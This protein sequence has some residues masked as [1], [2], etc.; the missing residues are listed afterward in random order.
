[1]DNDH[2]ICDMNLIHIAPQGGSPSD[3]LKEQTVYKLAEFITKMGCISLQTWSVV[4][5]AF[6]HD[7]HLHIYSFTMSDFKIRKEST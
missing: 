4:I 3:E 2:N 6:W 1:M 7:L 5:F